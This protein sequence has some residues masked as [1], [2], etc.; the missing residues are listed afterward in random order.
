MKNRRFL[1]AN[2]TVE[3]ALVMPVILSVLVLLV[4]FLLFLYN[5]NVLQDAALLGVKNA[6]YYEDRSNREIEESVA[7]KSFEAVRGRLIFMENLRMEVSVGKV[8]A[9]VHFVGEMKQSPFSLIGLPMPFQTVEVQAKADRF[10]P[11]AVIRNIRK[12][13]AF[14]EW[15]KERGTEDEGGIQTGYE[16]Q[17]SDSTGGISRLPAPDVYEE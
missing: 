2:I 10:R 4:A 1:D 14:I 6:T 12:G 3:C 16:M 8:Q 11:S 13:E 7:F 9:R 17:L 5:R 15:I